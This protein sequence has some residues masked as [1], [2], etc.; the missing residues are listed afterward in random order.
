MNNKQVQSAF[1]LLEFIQFCADSFNKPR[2]AMHFHDRLTMISHSHMWDPC[3]NS[4][5]DVI[6]AVVARISSE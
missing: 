2:I 4:V 1:K 5:N 6:M 3:E